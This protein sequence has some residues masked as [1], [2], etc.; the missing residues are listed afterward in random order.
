MKK[1]DLSISKKQKIYNI[2]LEFPE[3]RNNDIYLMKKLWEVEYP[4]FKI[5]NV[6]EFINKLVLKKITSP[7]TI[8]RLRQ[9]LQEKYTELRGTNYYIR[10]KVGEEIK[11]FLA[12]K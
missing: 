7:E 9:L 4:N 12:Q 1:S 6:N 2:L 5:L 11:I 3:T 10:H 8:R